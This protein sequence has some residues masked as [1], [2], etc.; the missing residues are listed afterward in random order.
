[1]VVSYSSNLAESETAFS[2]PVSHGA[3][4]PR[5]R[6]V[7]ETCEAEVKQPPARSA[8]GT[9]LRDLVAHP[10]FGQQL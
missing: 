3:R 4:V 7:H 10:G 6:N 8:E 9:V 5:K 1:M 2:L